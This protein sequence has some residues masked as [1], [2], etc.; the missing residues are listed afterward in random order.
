MYE[1]CATVIHD[2]GNW[3]VGM[4]IS[5]FVPDKNK[6]TKFTTTFQ[7]QLILGKNVYLTNIQERN[8]QKQAKVAVYEEMNWSQARQRFGKWDRWEFVEKTK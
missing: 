8:I 4:K 2:N 7:R 5:D 1:K 6:V 3:E